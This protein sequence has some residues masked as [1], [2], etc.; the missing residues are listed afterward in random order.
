MMITSIIQ[1][2]LLGARFLGKMNDQLWGNFIPI[3]EVS[4]FWTVPIWE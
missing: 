3:P 2:L 1:S 4:F